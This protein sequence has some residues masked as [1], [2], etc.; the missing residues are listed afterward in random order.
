MGDNIAKEYMMVSVGKYS[1]VN[2]ALLFTV[3]V[4]LSILVLVIISVDKAVNSV[5]R[6]SVRITRSF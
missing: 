6:S 3:P 1:S 5:N 4:S 2:K